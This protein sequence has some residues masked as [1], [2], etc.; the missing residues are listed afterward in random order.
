MQSDSCFCCLMWTEMICLFISLFIQKKSKH[1]LE[2]Y[3]VFSDVT[4]RLKNEV[5]VSPCLACLS[6]WAV[7]LYKRLTWNLFFY[8][9]SHNPFLFGA[10]EL[11]KHFLLLN[12]PGA[13][14]VL[15]EPFVLQA[16]TIRKGAQSIHSFSSALCGISGAAVWAETTR[17]PRIPIH[18]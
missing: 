6:V 15:F 3:S 12:A 7:D 16:C 5:S 4:V 11:W 17:L 18:R 2:N 9:L 8:F 1:P 14:T 13:E 10:G